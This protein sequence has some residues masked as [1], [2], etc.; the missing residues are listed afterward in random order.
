MCSAKLATN[1][2]GNTIVTQPLGGIQVPQT[3]VQMSRGL[4]ATRHSFRM[5]LIYTLGG[6][7][8]ALWVVQTVLFLLSYR[9]SRSS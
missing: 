2:A 5:T 6:I 7:L 3:K 4:P 8:L 1:A 9:Q